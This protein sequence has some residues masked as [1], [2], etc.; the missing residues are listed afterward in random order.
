ME[1]SDFWRIIAAARSARGNDRDSRVEALRERLAD[2]PPRELQS[3][4]NHYDSLITRAYRW[5]LWGAAYIINGGCSDDGFRYFRDWLISE[6]EEAYQA[7]LADPESLAKLRRI[8]LAEN[9]LF[10][11]V[12]FEL[13]EEARYW[14]RKRPWIEPL[15]GDMKGHGFDF[16]TSRLRHPE[17]LSRLMLAVA[18][19]YL[20]LCFLG[21]VALIWGRAKWVDRSDRRDRSIFTIGRQWL[22]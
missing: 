12:A 5:D 6:G 7:A 2:L 4:Q 16:Q 21:S 11:N 14:Y 19:A 22:N 3:F 17:R 8:P 1:I 9:E 20:W 10:G 15:F 18:L 13:F